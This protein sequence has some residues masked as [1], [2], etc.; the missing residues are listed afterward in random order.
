[1]GPREKRKQFVD[2]L[3]IYLECEKGAKPENHHKTAPLGHAVSETLGR[4]LQND[5]DVCI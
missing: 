4:V 2:F 5:G 1:M 3:F